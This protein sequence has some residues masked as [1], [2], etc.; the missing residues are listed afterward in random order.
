VLL[1]IAVCEQTSEEVSLE[2][3]LF[4]LLSAPKQGLAAD[5]TDETSM[6]NFLEISDLSAICDSCD[7]LSFLRNYQGDASLRGVISITPDCD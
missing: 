6:V 1:I 3:A 4:P 2:A 7:L 5:K